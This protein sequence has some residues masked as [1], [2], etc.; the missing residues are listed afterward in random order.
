MIHT[1]EL[2]MADS[3]DPADI[4]TFFDNT[5][6]AIC[7]TYHTVSKASSGAAIYGLNMLFDIP[8]AADWKQI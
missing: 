1:S 5:A 4:V 7:S 6:W 3:V 8:F 2:V